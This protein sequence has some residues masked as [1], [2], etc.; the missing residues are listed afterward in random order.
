MARTWTPALASGRRSADRADVLRAPVNAP[1]RAE[2][3][4]RSGTALGTP[5]AR[6]GVV[7]PV[8]GGR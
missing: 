6:T 4:P 3:R 2:G 8:R 1:G 5:T 7:D